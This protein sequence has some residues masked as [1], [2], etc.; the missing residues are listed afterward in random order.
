MRKGLFNNVRVDGYT[1]VL[2][3]EAEGI[4]AV[5]DVAERLRQIALA[6]DIVGVLLGPDLECLDLRAAVR[7]PDSVALVGTAA[8]DLRFDVVERSDPVHRLTGDVRAGLFLDLEEGP[9][10]MR[11][12]GCFLEWAAPFPSAR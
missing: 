4:P 11:P 12:T 6:R 10:Q 1:P 2:E 5:Q 3:E 9:S 7:L 8:V